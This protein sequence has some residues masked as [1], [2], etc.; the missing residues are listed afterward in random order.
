MEFD[1][2]ILSHTTSS[3]VT[4]FL[5]LKKAFKYV[6]FRHM[7]PSNPERAFMERY[8][9]DTY[10]CIYIKC[11]L[12]IQGD[13]CTPLSQNLQIWSQRYLKITG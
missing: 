12:E 8:Q 11:S 4:S 2:T 1:G 10:I 7:L 5:V 6:F 13:I 9:H 3:D